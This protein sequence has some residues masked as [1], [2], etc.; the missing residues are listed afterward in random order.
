MVI[1]LHMYSHSIKDYERLVPLLTSQGYAVLNLDLRGHGESTKRGQETLDYLYPEKVDFRLLPL[2]VEFALDALKPY[3]GRIDLDRV[4]IIGASIGANAGLIA[5][6]G[7][8]KIKA[9]VLVSPGLN[10]HELKTEQSASRLTD[11]A[12][13]LICSRGDNY[14]LSSC[15]RLNSIM[16]TSNKETKLVEGSEQGNKLLLKIPTLNKY[17]AR[18]IRE[19]LPARR[20]DQIE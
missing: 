15:E 5:A 14:S 3:L 13:L 6:G 2:D 12:I 8:P 18:W 17:V 19:N 7:N 4:G 1:L 10:Y 9:L 16:P 20:P 11:T